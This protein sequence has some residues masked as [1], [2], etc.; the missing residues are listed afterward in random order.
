[1]IRRTVRT[2]R[3][4]RHCDGCRALIRPGERYVECVASPHHDDLANPMW[5]RL[6]DCA[7]CSAR[8]GKP[9]PTPKESDD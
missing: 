4:H 9:I 8:R 3:L 6:D 7:E 5:W 1:M 2:S